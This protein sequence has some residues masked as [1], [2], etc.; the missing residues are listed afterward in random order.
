M[1]RKITFVH[2]ID[3]WK[4]RRLYFL[5]LKFTDYVRIISPTMDTWTFL[6]PSCFASCIRSHVTGFSLKYHIRRIL[7]PFFVV[8]RICGLYRGVITDENRTAKKINRDYTLFIIRVRQRRGPK[9]L[10][11]GVCSLRGLHGLHELLV[12]HH[13][14]KGRKRFNIFAVSKSCTVHKQKNG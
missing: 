10:S 11:F 2:T 7:W 5:L 14:K 1:D 9:N 13:T 6:F 4:I 8:I 3:H 12:L